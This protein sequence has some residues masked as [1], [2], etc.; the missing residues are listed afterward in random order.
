MPRAARGELAARPWVSRIWKTTPA[1]RRALP[2][3]ECHPRLARDVAPADRAGRSTSVT[4][5]RGAGSARSPCA[6][7][8]RP[9]AAASTRLATASWAGRGAQ[10]ETKALRET[11]LVTCSSS[12]RR[13]ADRAALSVAHHP[14]SKHRRPR[15]AA[16]A[17]GMLHRGELAA[18][19]PTRASVPAIGKRPFTLHRVAGRRPQPVARARCRCG[20]RRPPAD[21]AL[22]SCRSVTYLHLS[23]V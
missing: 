12:G 13:I 19:E 21:R 3:R 15:P 4:R 7:A 1:G 20:R 2:G 6:R 18:R 23:S 22:P 17:G 5:V 16:E 10:G 11:L 14:R 8:D 9:R